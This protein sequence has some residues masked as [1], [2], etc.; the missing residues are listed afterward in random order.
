VSSSTSI[1]DHLY[2]EELYTVTSPVLIIISQGWDE[3]TEEHKTL[4]TKILGSVKL[5]PALVNIITRKEFDAVSVDVYSPRRIISFGASLKSSAA[6]YEHIKVGDV[7]V[8][9]ADAVDKLDDAKK[10]SLWLALRKMFE[11]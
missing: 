5:S 3:L 9:V 2:Q 10:K 8:I 4:L 1:F 6:L 11:I 7:S